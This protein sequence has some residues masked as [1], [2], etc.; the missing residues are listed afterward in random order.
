MNPTI[1]TFSTIEELADICYRWIKKKTE[2][3]SSV[4]LALSGGRTPQALFEV[5]KNLD[6]SMISVEKLLIFWGDER[7]VPPNDVESNYGNAKKSLIEYIGIPPQNIFRIFGENEPESE[8]VR[9][10]QVIESHLVIENGLPK[11]DLILLGLGDDGHTASIFP[12]NEQLFTYTE[13]C[14]VAKH[15]LSGQKRITLTGRLL[16]NAHDVVFLVTGSSK[17][18]II[19]EVLSNQELMKYPA[20]FVRPNSG[21]LTWLLDEAA[22]PYL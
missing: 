16:N 13:L 11:F 5:F 2:Q 7:C 12:G 6:W 1:Q 14:A 3:Q 17:S 9:Y 22:N 4:S 19:K 21:N 20:S 8:A 10:A 18:N 15:P